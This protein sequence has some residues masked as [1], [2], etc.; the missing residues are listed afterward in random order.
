MNDVDLG[1]T[2]GK[3]SEEGEQVY[4]RMCRYHNNPIERVL[5]QNMEMMEG[6]K[7]P[8]IQKKKQIQLAS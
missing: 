1:E 3:E 6:Y 8:C 4:N 2:E 5:W 7:F